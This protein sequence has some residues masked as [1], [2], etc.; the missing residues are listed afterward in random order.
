MIDLHCHLLPGVDD[1][2]ADLETSVAMAEIARRDGITDVVVTPHQRHYRWPNEDSAALAEAFGALQR[3]IGEGLRLVL[4][5]EVRVDSDLLDDLESH[6][7][8]RRILPLGGSRALL[9]EFDV[10]PTGPAPEDVVHELIVGGWRPVVAHPE[11][12]PWLAEEPERIVALAAMGAAIQIT[13]MSVTGE[14]GRRAQSCS[15]FLLDRRAVHVL[16][17]DAHGVDQR[18]PVLSGA[19]ARVADGWGEE[20]AD[21]LTRLNPEAIL[22]DRPL[23]SVNPAREAA[24]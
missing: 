2:A 22:A 23:A 14:W 9:I 10:F 18:P 19:R 7:P 8:G 1:G 24:R 20:T 11:R 15:R 6:G 5:A 17:T 16:A 13:A 12:I 21:R 4:G 3:R